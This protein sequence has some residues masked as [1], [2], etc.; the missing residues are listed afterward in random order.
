MDNVGKIFL[1]GCL[2]LFLIVLIGIAVTSCRSAKKI[3][4][5]IS[6]KDTALRKTDT[7]TAED[8]HADSLK[9]IQKLYSHIKSNTIDCKTFS[10]KLK[11]HY[12]GTD[13]KDYEFNAFIRLQK[14]KMI[15]IS[16]NALLGIEAFRAVLTPDSVKVLNKL[17]KIYQLRSVSYLQEISHL[18]FDFNTL[19]SIVLGNP[20]YLD[21]NILFYRKDVQG[22]SFLSIGLLFRNYLTLNNDF[23]LKHSILDDVD[24]MKA[25]S[26]DI[27]YGDYEK[28]DTVLFST[29]RKIVV[30]EKGILD[31]EMNFKNIRFNENLDYPFSIPKNYKRN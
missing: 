20:V 2:G 8:L 5:A 9:Y 13:G 26:C 25:R 10:A 6:K 18:P 17:D 1:N 27:T 3:T 14:D 4:T 21:S 24:Q 15:W 29:Y 22:I 19:Q 31:V 12:E 11:V 16:I 23:S 28:V 30:S 7:A